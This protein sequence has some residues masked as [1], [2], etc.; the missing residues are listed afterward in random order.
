[1]TKLEYSI[2]LSGYTPI[3]G[4]GETGNDGYSV[5]F[6]TINID[7]VDNIQTIKD[8]ITDSTPMSNNPA[9]RNAETEEYKINDVIIDDYGNFG[10]IT[11]IGSSP[12][13]SVT[14]KIFQ[15]DN[16]DHTDDDFRTDSSLILKYNSAKNWD[17]NT[18]NFYSFNTTYNRESF[19]DEGVKCPLYSHRDNMDS[20]VYGNHYV[21]TNPSTSY[22][23]IRKVLPKCYFAKII[24]TFSTGLIYEK[25]ARSLSDFNIF[26][27]NRYYY[28]YGRGVAERANYTL[29]NGNNDASVNGTVDSSFWGDLTYTLQKYRPNDGGAYYAETEQHVSDVCRSINNPKM[30]GSNIIMHSIVH[31]HVEFYAK[32]G[33]TYDVGLLLKNN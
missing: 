20:S 4:K 1:M 19:E 29:A 17:T 22:N 16:I 5:H 25:I 28:G 6:S 15:F 30:S 2:G 31:A 26:I 10:V 18:Y 21:L 23:F 13:F 27:D 32:D 3:E 8:C 9:A 12:E 14:G 33:H 11:K 24:I 7:D